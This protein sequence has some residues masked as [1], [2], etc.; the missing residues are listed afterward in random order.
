M[1]YGVHKAHPPGVFAKRKGGMSSGV[2][3]EQHHNACAIAVKALPREFGSLV[4]ID[5]EAAC[6][7]KFLHGH[8][9]SWSRKLQPAPQDPY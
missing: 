2:A 1:A 5:P 9:N 6:G 7:L 3:E 4:K 8:R